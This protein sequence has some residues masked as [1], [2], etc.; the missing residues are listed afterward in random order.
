MF[1]KVDCMHIP[2][3]NGSKCYVCLGIKIKWLKISTKKTVLPLRGGSSDNE[4]PK[5]GRSCGLKR[6]S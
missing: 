4:N 6:T 3:M 1:G 5:G 2:C